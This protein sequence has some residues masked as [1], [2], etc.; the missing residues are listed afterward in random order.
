MDQLEAAL[1]AMNAVSSDQHVT[2]VEHH[3]QQQH[4]HQEQKTETITTM[5]SQTF[6]S[7][8]QQQFQQSVSILQRSMSP[9]W[10]NVVGYS[11]GNSVCITTLFSLIL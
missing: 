4:H 3:Q 2:K 10:D 1:S 7:Q 5:T 11:T 9:V 8:Q 6:E